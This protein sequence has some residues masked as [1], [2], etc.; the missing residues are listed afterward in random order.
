MN[1]LV[2]KGEEGI[3]GC[4][5]LNMIL[6]HSWTFCHERFIDFALEYKKK[7]EQ[8]SKC[9]WRAAVDCSPNKHLFSGELLIQRNPQPKK[10]IERSFS[11]L[12]GLAAKM[13]QKRHQFLDEL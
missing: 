9:G 10:R 5:V 12:P 2:Y 8:E 1:S 4:F 7:Y 13:L 3:G 11:S 6:D